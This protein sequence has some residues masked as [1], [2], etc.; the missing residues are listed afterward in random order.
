MSKIT[1]F[2]FGIMWSLIFVIYQ[3]RP[4]PDRDIITLLMGLLALAHFGW[5]IT[6]HDL[7]KA[8]ADLMEK[9]I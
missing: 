8:K 6:A 2:I 4:T 3:F 7:Q 5:C 9:Q 1:L